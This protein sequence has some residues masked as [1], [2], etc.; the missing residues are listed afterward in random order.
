MNGV[1]LPTTALLDANAAPFRFGQQTAFGERLGHL[2]GQNDV[3]EQRP[4]ERKREEVTEMRM[5]SENGG[6]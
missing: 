5:V 3:S 4:A 6:G 2:L 1:V